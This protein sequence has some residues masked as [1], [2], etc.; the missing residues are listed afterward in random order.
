[1]SFINYYELLEIESGADAD[2]VKQAANKKRTEWG[3]LEHPEGA[4]RTLAEQ[5]I[6]G[7]EEAETVLLDPSKR[8]TFDRQLAAAQT[9][10]SAMPHSKSADDRD[11]VSIAV[12]QLESGIASQANQAAREATAH[13]PD[14]AEAWYLRG[15][16]SKRL[17]HETDAEFELAEA[18]RLDPNEPAYYGELGRV[19]SETGRHA[20]ALEAYERAS[21]LDPTELEYKFFVAIALENLDRNSEALAIFKQIHEAEPDNGKYHDGYALGLISDTTSQWSQHGDGTSSI[22]T[23]SQLA[24]A[25]KSLSAL[26]GFRGS[27]PAGREGIV[28]FTEFVEAASRKKWDRSRHRFAY[29]MLFIFSLIAMFQSEDAINFVVRLAIV[30]LIPI[31]YV[32]RHHMPAWKWDSKHVDESVRRTGLQ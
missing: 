3:E 19:Y 32:I 7:I 20:L 22:L 8:A 21:E 27:S 17:G 14:S 6:E 12:E 26:A 30:V 13:Q 4:M 31:V 18:V 1:M 16:S 11:W 5:T 9:G 24:L 29:L 23:A 25:R 15:I 10:S 28:E 2:T